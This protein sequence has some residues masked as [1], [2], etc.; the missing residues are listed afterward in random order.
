[1][2]RVHFIGITGVGMSATAILMKEAGYDVTGSD[3]E[4]Y[5]P[6]KAILEHA[7]IP[8]RIGYDS[9]QLPEADEYVIG[10]NAKL[11]PG[12]NPEVDAAVASGKPIRSFP[13]VIGALTEERD[14][15]VVAGSY[16]KS[17]T[18][19]IIAHLL[20]HKDGSAGYFVGAEPLSLPAPAKLGTGI[21]VAEGDEYP[22]AHDD[23]R[24][25]F[26]HLHPTDVVLTSVVH[27]HVNVYPTL[28]DYKK[29]FRELLA[30]VPENGTVIVCADEPGA[31][32]VAKESGKTLVE[33]GLVQGT[34]RAASIVFGEVTRFSLMKNGEQIALLS[35]TLLGRHNVE[36][37]TAA[38]AY[39]LSRELLTPEQLAEGIATFTGVRRRLDRV[40]PDSRLRVFE[41][42]GSSYEKAISAIDAIRLHFPDRRLVVV[43]EPH[44]FGW[45]N[46]AN[47]HWYDTVFNSASLV[48]VAPLARQ[49][50]GTHEQLTQE[51]VMSRIG[52]S[53]I[54]AQVYDPAHPEEVSAVLSEDDVVLILSSGDLEGSLPALTASLSEKFPN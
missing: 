7:G 43:F 14:V 30:L 45:R 33:Y 18:T 13:E 23:A 19:S 37:I 40:A 10:R 47:L 28:E 46:R 20:A 9:A 35:T 32:E 1:M 6:T 42:F 22:S 51:E 41:G 53:G 49:G 4:A 50:A 54:A 38:S 39:V 52:A 44:T 26:M 34:Y 16:G 25:K 11:R 2:K 12:E 29:P 5:G 24:A 8:V 27:D 48:F 21:F 36:D 17:T 31:L 15:C 3:T